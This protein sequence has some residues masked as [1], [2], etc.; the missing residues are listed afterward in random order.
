MA[1]DYCNHDKLSHNHNI[2][3]LAVSD[4]IKIVGHSEKL[5]STINYLTEK[6]NYIL[7]Q[8]ELWLF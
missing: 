4:V 5:G 2:Y 6:V 7:S 3:L 8:R 1:G